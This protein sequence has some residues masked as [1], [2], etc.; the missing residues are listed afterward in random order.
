MNEYQLTDYEGA[1][2]QAD[3]IKG[4]AENIMSIFDDID[5]VMND[6]YGNHWTL[7]SGAEDTNAMYNE[8]RKNYEV[9]YEAVKKMHKDIN[10]SVANYEEADAAAQATISGASGM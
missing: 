6:L 1:R 4:N 7:S 3:A 2:S 9:F 8:I 5:K 10:A